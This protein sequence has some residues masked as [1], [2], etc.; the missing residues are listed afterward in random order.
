MDPQTTLFQQSDFVVVGVKQLS[1]HRVQFTFDRRLIPLTVEYDR[2]LKSDE[3]RNA[4]SDNV[5]SDKMTQIARNKFTNCEC[6]VSLVKD[7]TE[8]L[9]WTVSI[10][11]GPERIKAVICHR[12]YLDHLYDYLNNQL[13]KQPQSVPSQPQKPPSKVRR[14]FTPITHYYQ[15]RSKFIRGD[16]DEDD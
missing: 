2:W 3:A 12:K 9:A 8:S 16:H 15:H 7:F 14:D 6:M 5:Y 1:P 10:N 4:A 13:P 11:I